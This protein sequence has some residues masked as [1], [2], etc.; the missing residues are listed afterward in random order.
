[1]QKNGKIGKSEAAWA[2]VFLIYI[3]S[4]IWFYYTDQPSAAIIYT[5]TSFILLR[6]VFSY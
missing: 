5:F 3:A 1:M 4:A 2:V 6:R